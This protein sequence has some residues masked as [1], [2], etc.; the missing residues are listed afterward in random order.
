MAD[1]KLSNLL[2]SLNGYQSIY[3]YIYGECKK[4]KQV[5]L[6]LHVETSMVL[7]GRK[8]GLFRLIF[9]IILLHMF[10]FISGNTIQICSEATVKYVDWDIDY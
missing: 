3:S 9:Q 7:A 1:F 2:I 4:R 6:K 10:P 8:V 5:K